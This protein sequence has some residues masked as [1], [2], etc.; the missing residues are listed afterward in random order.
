[1]PPSLSPDTSAE[2]L[3]LRALESYGDLDGPSRAGLDDLARLTS[4][5]FSV[6]LALVSLVDRDTL[7]VQAKVGTELM[8][9]PR[10]IAPCNVTIGLP[11]VTVV[12]DTLQDARF[13]N[14]PMVVND[15]KIR[16]YA[17]APLHTSEGHAIGTLCVMDYTPR[18][19]TPEQQNMLAALSRQAMA[20]LD[21]HK[22]HELSQR[23]RSDLRKLG[24]RLELALKGSN[25]GWWD[26]DLNTGD[27]YLSERGLEMLGYDSHEVPHDDRIREHLVHPDDLGRLNEVIATALTTGQTRYSAEV[28]MRHKAGFD[29]PI[30]SRGYISRDASGKP[31]RISGMITDLTDFQRAQ[32]ARQ[33][34][35]ESYRRLFANSM[36]G[37]MLGRAQDGLLYAVN[38][39]ACAMLG[40]SEAD[41]IQGGR[42]IFLDM[43]DPRMPLLFAKRSKHGF[44]QGELN[45]LRSDG[46]PFEVEISSV[47]FQD[48]DGVVMAST[49]FRDNTLHKQAQADLRIA[50]TAFES[51]EGIFVCNA[52]WI[53]LKVNRAFS[54]LTGYSAAE[55][56]GQRPNELLGSGRSDASFYV[57]MQRI[58]GT[59]G[60]W[61]GEVWDKRKDGEVYPAWLTVTVL[62][63]DDGHPTHYV[64]TM[65]DI[66]DR[67]QAEAEIRNLAFYDPLTGL[68]NR[69]L[70]VD[71]LGQALNQRSRHQSLGAL[72]FLDLDNFKVLNDT[73]GHDQGDQLL[74]QVAQRLLTCVREGDTVA[75][76][77]GDEFVVML[78]DLSGDPL[79]AAR[80]TE[81]VGEKVL[82]KLNQVYVLSDASHRSTP[83]IGVTLFGDRAESIEEPLK[84]ADLAMYQA[85]AAGRNALRFYDAGM[86]A[87]VSQ[88]LSL[89]NDLR[90][91]LSHGQLLLYYQVQ[92]QLDGRITGAEVLCRWQHPQRGMVSPAEFIPLAEECGVILPLGRW[93]LETA[94]QQIQAWSTEPALAQLTLSVNVSARQLT[95]PDFVDTV[96][97]IL[98]STG[99]DPRKIKLELTEGVLVSDVDNTIAKMKALKSVGIGFSMDDFGTG[100]SS[101]S[102]LKLLPLDQ[103]KID[104]GFVRDILVD[105]NDAAIAKMVIALADSLG[106][107][108]I[109][110]GVE[111]KAQHDFLAAQGC[112]AYQGY[113]YGKPS[114]LEA[115]EILARTGWAL[116][117]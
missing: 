23:E 33:D 43:H 28:R 27:S 22:E 3:R 64:A 78:L 107:A 6:P 101:L 60:T 52:D 67:K 17:G 16:F 40:R 105:A 81:L 77:G 89:E 20:L 62:R 108:V 37:V 38:P 102:F 11:S 96:M 42:K 35:E 49:V 70:L 36:D 99:A 24:D 111:T 45:F 94:C 72:L 80:Q 98:Q 30:M 21:L 83:S 117:S 12:P 73:L 92:V 116:P 113:W 19:F 75:R 9:L 112:L 57:E 53:I 85:K 87:A 91:A 106:L 74:M 93:V 86:Q 10:A 55:A 26:R 32:K 79:H 90:E 39:A 110:E 29:L 88:R 1:M 109:A 47:L 46:T 8:R 51:Q 48:A 66:T 31:T 18:S 103:L 58:L 71:R 69:R 15:A 5:Y 115:F 82:D 61:Q 44:V 65:T 56:L 104:Q 100:Y 84:R 50:A 76:L 68:P 59:E 14:N 34:S 41:I 95:R 97:S 54:K 25:D 114:T 4:Q 63:E 7:N 2:D 13:A